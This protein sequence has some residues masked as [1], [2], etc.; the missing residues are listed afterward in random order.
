MKHNNIKKLISNL[1]GV[2]EIV[3]YSW[4][5]TLVYIRNICAHHGRLWNR[6]IRISPIIMK[7][8]LFKNKW[9][10]NVNSINNKK[11][12]YIFCIVKYLLNIINPANQFKEK[13][14]MTFSKYQNSI[15]LNAMGFTN[16]WESE[17]LWN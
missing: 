11:I 10:R 12:Y 16:N 3:F 1:F 13:L 14:I 4:F 2:S 15:D 7:N 5:H 8:P 9:L 6:T 17:Q